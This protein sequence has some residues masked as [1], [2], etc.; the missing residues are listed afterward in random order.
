[1]TLDGPRQPD[2]LDIDLIAASLRS[3][4]S[5]LGAFV[6]ALAV[7]LE[8]AVPGGVKVYRLR[9]RMFGPKLVRK[10]TVDAGDQRLELR[11]AG[12]GIETSCSRMSGGIVLKSEPIDTEGW[13]AAL[14]QALAEEARRSQTTKQALERMLNE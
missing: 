8:E 9:G 10:I 3:D 14:G 11:R 6:E 13:L 2:A 4:T 5:D 12:A 1:M 7:K